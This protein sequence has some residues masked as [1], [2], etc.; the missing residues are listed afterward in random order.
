MGKEKIDKL[1][2]FNGGDSDFIFS[3]MLI[4]N[5]LRFVFILS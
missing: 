4:E 2:C 3:D 1:F 5:F